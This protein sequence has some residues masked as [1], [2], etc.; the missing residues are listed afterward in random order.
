MVLN[1][2]NVKNQLSIYLANGTNV[3]RRT[4]AKLMTKTKPHAVN[5]LFSSRDKTPSLSVPLT[6]FVN[7]TLEIVTSRTLTSSEIVP[8]KW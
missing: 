5:I 7:R 2:G 4:N 6:A 3:V 1:G 8:G